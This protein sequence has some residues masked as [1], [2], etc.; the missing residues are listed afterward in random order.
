MKILCKLF[1]HKWIKIE[2]VWLI[3]YIYRCKR[4]GLQK[5]EPTI[6]FFNRRYPS[7]YM[8]ARAFHED[9]GDR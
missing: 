2:E 9:C 5:K 1:G 8:G 3:K 4:C 6:S 7:D